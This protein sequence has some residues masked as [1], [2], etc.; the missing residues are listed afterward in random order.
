MDERNQPKFIFF[1]IGGL[2]YAEIRVLHEFENSNAYLNVI[3]GSTA[4]VKPQDF[5]DGISQML[6]QSEYDQLKQKI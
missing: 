1:V 6:T 2:S 4:I 3:S 5:I